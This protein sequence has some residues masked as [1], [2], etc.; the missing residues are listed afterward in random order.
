MSSLGGTSS[1][2]YLRIN[3]TTGQV[4]VDVSS[5]RYKDN[6][7]PLKENFSEILQLEPK[8][9]TDKTSNLKEVGYIAEDLDKLGLNYLVNYDNESLPQSIKYDRIPLYMMEVVKDQQKQIDELKSIVCL[10]HPDAEL[11]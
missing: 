3:T 9:Y 8:S 1:Y 11:C 7:Q 6:I 2:A 4:F 5:A 10:D